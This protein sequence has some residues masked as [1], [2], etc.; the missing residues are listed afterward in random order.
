MCVWM[1]YVYVIHVY[2]IIASNNF[3]TLFLIIHT[4]INIWIIIWELYSQ[5]ENGPMLPLLIF[6]LF[7]TKIEFRRLISYMLYAHIESWW[8]N[9]YHA[10]IL[11]WPKT[12]G[13]KYC[14][15]LHPAIYYTISF[16]LFIY[17]TFFLT[18]LFLLLKN[19]TI[20]SL[21]ISIHHNFQ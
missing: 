17:I 12:R 14:F 15:L 20:M 2:S 6:I 9:V 7:I 13:K 16:F 3:N 10:K 18:C 19:D 11:G 1:Y 21:F 4:G 8:M 5:G